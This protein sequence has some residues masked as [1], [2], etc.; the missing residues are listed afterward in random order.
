MTALQ[1]HF[2][3]PLTMRGHLLTAIDGKYLFEGHVPVGLVSGF[4]AGA[5]QERDSVVVTQDSMASDVKSYYMMSGNG[6][7]LECSIN[8]PIA[9]CEQQGKA[10]GSPLSMLAGNLVLPLMV[11]LAGIAGLYVL[12]KPGKKKQAEI[13]K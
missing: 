5:A 12:L 7:V 3:V 11:A 8:T 6:G 9:A 13:T 4:M 1:E 10:A 2:N